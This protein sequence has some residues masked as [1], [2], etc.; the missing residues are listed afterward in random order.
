M[1]VHGQAA[2]CIAQKELDRKANGNLID[3]H[4]ETQ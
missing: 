4:E 2:F 3:S 1:Q